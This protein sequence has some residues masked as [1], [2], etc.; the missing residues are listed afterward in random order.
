MK[1]DSQFPTKFRRCVAGFALACIIP[2][3]AGAV[4]AEQADTVVAMV[5][6]DKV[7]EGEFFTRLQRLKAQDFI[8]KPK[9]LTMR[10]DSAGAMVLVSIINEH[11]IIQLARKENVLPTEAQVQ[12][13]LAPILGQENVKKLIDARMITAGQLAYDIRV[14][15]ARRNLEKKLG[16]HGAAE[17][18]MAAFR[19][20]S[21]I[22][23]VLP[24]YETLLNVP[25]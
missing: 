15:D 8:L 9:P 3:L 5:N 14:Q 24:G 21:Q 12:A 10:S 17:K 7:Y 22:T 2:A 4:S 16:G 1:S 23:I 25:K 13:Q 20:S 18:S 19:K 11:V 6:N